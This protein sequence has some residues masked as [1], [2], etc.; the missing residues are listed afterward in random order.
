M[1][2][3]FC[4]DRFGARELSKE[5]VAVCQKKRE[6]AAYIYLSP[7]IEYQTLEELL[8][9]QGLFEQKY[10]V[11]CD[12]MLDDYSGRHLVDNISLYSGSPHMFVVFEPSLGVRDEKNLLSAGAVIKRCKEQKT[13]SED[14]RP[15]FAFIDMFLRGDAEK[16]F[17]TL[18]SLL[19]NGGLPSSVLNMVL[20]QLRMLVLVSHSDSATSAGVKPFVYTKAQKALAVIND[21]F[22]LFVRAEEVVREGRLRGLQDAEIAEYLVLDL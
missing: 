5:F 22:D 7:A 21:P 13:T 11:F 16:S 4:G 8:L 19:R 15:V 3:V 6:R 18:H 17:I 10:I 9:G 1:L 12:E 2:Y 20:W 14:M